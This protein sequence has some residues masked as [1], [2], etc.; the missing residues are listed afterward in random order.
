MLERLETES[1]GQEVSYKRVGNVSFWNG[2]RLSEGGAILFPL[3][4]VISY[5]VEL[6]KNFFEERQELPQTKKAPILQK[7]TVEHLNKAFQELP[8][9]PRKKLLSPIHNFPIPNPSRFDDVP[10]LK[11]QMISP[12]VHA[13][14]I[15]IEGH[16]FPFI[17][18]QT[19]KPG[20]PTVN[21]L[22]ALQ[23]QGCKHLVWLVPKVEM[24]EK[25]LD[26]YPLV[27]GEYLE[28][29]QCID[30]SQTPDKTTYTLQKDGYI[31][32]I[33]QITSW[34]DHGV[35][36]LALFKRFLASIE[37]AHRDNSTLAVSCRAGIGRTGTFIQALCSEGNPDV[38]H[39][40]K[41]AKSLREQR[42]GAIQTEEQFLFAYSMA[43]D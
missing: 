32:N 42:W 5:I 33:H 39:F 17:A 37:K 21:F 3:Q 8:N 13:N 2:Y 9:G 36:D 28:S 38:S 40:E 29:Y 18:A 27:K 43:S 24:K 1:L 11:N 41:V 6:I 19:P 4:K 15:R 22:D 34:P 10:C 31:L 7:E 30:V 35:P 26:V 14:L 12:A 16:P 23:H 25:E 20:S